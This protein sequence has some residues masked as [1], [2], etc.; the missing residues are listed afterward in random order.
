MSGQTVVTASPSRRTT[1]TGGKSIHIIWNSPVRKA[2][3]GVCYKYHKRQHGGKTSGGFSRV[4]GTSP[5]PLDQNFLIFMQ[6][7]GK[8]GQILG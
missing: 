5:L 2:W 6:F 4:Q 1:Y 7:S 8:I 3:Q